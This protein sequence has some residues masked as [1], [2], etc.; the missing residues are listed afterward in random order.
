MSLLPS[1]LAYLLTA[2][3]GT[4]S[5]DLPDNKFADIP[6]KREYIRQR[7]VGEVE[8]GTVL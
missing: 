1:D 7:D 2:D 5:R 6:L 8:R 4:V 3:K